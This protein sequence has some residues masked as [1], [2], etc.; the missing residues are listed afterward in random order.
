MSPII[1]AC[2]ER[3]LDFSVINTRQHFSDNMNTSFFHDLE[4]PPPVFTLET[5]SG[6]HGTQF[7]SMLPKL[8]ELFETNSFDIVLVQGDTNTV[9]AGAF[10]ASR[11]GIAIGHVEAGLRSGDK[12]MPEE[13]NRIMVDHIADFCFATSETTLNNLHLEGLKGPHILNVGNTVVDATMRG[14]ELARRSVEKAAFSPPKQPYM[15]VT[16]HRASNVDNPETLQ[17]IMDG[18]HESLER[19]GLVAIFPVH[20]RTN[21]QIIANNIKLPSK[22]KLI[23]PLGY[24][25]F[26]RLH[27]GATIMLTDSGG[28]QEEACIMHVPCVTVRENTER[29]E[30]IDIGANLLGRTDP[31]SIVHAVDHMLKAPKNWDI[32]YGDGTAGAKIVDAILNS[33]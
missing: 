10:M 13:T 21:K 6:S 30:T 29:P 32:P 12:S 27:S 9:F 14:L 4:L 28:V 19:H 17:G 31:K 2:Q 15:L 18:I 26:L 5:A 16:I 22:M 1:V 11:Q 8:E 3:G 33:K 7:A 20:P 24:L 25:D 23:E